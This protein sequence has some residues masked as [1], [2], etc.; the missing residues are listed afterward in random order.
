MVTALLVGDPS[1]ARPAA[2]ASTSRASATRATRTCPLNKHLVPRCGVLWGAYAQ[3]VGNQQALDAF[4]HLQRVTGSRF[5]IVHY[6]HQGTELFPSPW[7]IQLSQH[8]RHLLINWKPEAGHTWAEVA[9]GAADG[10]LDS[11]ASYLLQNYRKRF[12]L[13][14]HHEPENEVI[15]TPGSGMTAADYRAMF[16]HV[17]SRLRADG[18]DN[19]VYVMNYMGAQT[20]AER[21]WYDQL[22]PGRRFVD[23]IAFDPYDAP[24]LDPQSGGFKKMVNRHWGA[25][26]W[27]GS[28]RWAHQHFPSKPVMLAEWGAAEKAG[29]PGWK[30]AFFTSVVPDLRAMPRLKLLA[31]FSSPTPT[32]GGDVRPNTSAGSTTAWRRLAGRPIFHRPGS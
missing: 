18:V 16:R 24:G 6:Y 25:G 12:F 11:E 19:A 29:S 21:A 31:Y 32:V 4:R 22:W 7:E 3:A 1:S 2:P 5:S 23:W 13:V 14:I 30:S 10:Y 20:Y 8:H 9:K 15:N 17:E 28:Y 26:V 27:R